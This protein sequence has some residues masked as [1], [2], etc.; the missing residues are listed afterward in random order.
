MKSKRKL[1]NVYIKPEI[2]GYTVLSFENGKKII[3]NGEY[4][5]RNFC[6]N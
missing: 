4:A 3:E 5:T 2:K 1:T 6:Q